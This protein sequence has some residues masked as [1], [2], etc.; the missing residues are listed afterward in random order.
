MLFLLPGALS[1]QIFTSEFQLKRHFLREAP[2]PPTADPTPCPSYHHHLTL[3][4]VLVSSFL[5]CLPDQT[6]SPKTA[7]SG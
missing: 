4:Y 6:A 5:I 7:G 1:S 2:P 3:T